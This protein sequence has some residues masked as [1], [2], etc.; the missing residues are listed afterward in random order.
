MS[1]QGSLINLG[2]TK[3]FEA[4]G[5]KQIFTEVH[6]LINIIFIRKY[7]CCLYLNLKQLN[8]LVR[9]MIILTSKRV[10]YLN[11]F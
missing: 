7:T 11:S 6:K 10:I 2:N 3:L 1:I 9:Q 8:L 4:S 5:R